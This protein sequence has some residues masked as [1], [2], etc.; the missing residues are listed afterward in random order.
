MTMGKS[1]VLELKASRIARP[2]SGDL[3]ARNQVLVG[4]VALAGELA[5][6]GVSVDDL[7]RGTGVAPA[8]LDNPSARISHRQRLAIYRNA[9]TLSRHPEIALS[10]GARQRLSDYGIYGYAMLSSATFGDALWISLEHI[11]MAGPAV[12]E[13]SFDIEGSSAVLRSRGFE[14]L[15]DLL[16][17]AAEL[18]RSST[19]TLFSHV[20]EAPFPSQS[21]SFPFSRPAHWRRYE[22]LFNCDIAFDAPVMEWR[23]SADVLKRP[24][25]NAN[26]VTAQVCQ[27]F[28]DRMVGDAGSESELSQRIRAMCMN[29]S[30]LFPRV[31]EIAPK[32][33]MSSRT[34][35]R[36]LAQE[37]RSYQSVLDDLRR[38]MAIEFLET[39]HL[40]IETIA[41]RVGFSDAANFRKA[42][43]KMDQTTTL[44]L[45]A[46]GSS[47]SSRRSKT[48]T[49]PR[50][51]MARA[52]YRCRRDGRIFESNSAGGHMIKQGNL[53]RSACPPCRCSKAPTPSS[54]FRGGTGASRR[55]AATSVRLQGS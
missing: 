31:E 48:R 37:G 12:R 34:L 19:S 42:F 6:Q 36:R 27:Q 35:H 8:E 7:F 16:P 25:P 1:A 24:C 3:D 28:L 55:K 32:L 15:G 39:T 41:L 18:W 14:A 45:S 5:S 23:F 46:I 38:A 10:A 20:I 40:S 53:L 22:R 47:G 52:L 26:T 54:P 51:Q 43:Q 9:W 17:F 33:G 2:L 4:L 30:G 50:L 13:I 44:S 11:T 21:M 29:G 49:F